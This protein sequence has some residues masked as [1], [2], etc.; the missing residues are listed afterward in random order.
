MPPPARDQVLNFW[1]DARDPGV[2]ND[3]VDEVLLS[4]ERDLRQALS[5]RGLTQKDAIADLENALGV[6]AQECALSGHPVSY[7]PAAQ[8]FP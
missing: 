1:E 3:T 5:E 6:V 4:A 7:I 2:V 8:A